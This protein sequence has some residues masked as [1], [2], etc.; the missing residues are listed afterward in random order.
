MHQVICPLRQKD[1]TSQMM[2]AMEDKWATQKSVKMMM[3]WWVRQ[4]KSIIYPGVIQ[5]VYWWI[6]FHS[7][8]IQYIQIYF[9]DQSTWFERCRDHVSFQK[10]SK[11]APFYSSVMLWPDQFQDK[12]RLFFQMSLVTPGYLLWPLCSVLALR[13]NN[14]P[15]S[16]SMHPKHAGLE[17]AIDPYISL[18][19]QK[20]T[21]RMN[22]AT[23]APTK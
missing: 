14:F 2:L 5:Y 23:G 12:Y 21:L 19:V 1:T 4:W 18:P 10:F 15:S 3:F 7:W 16:F 13:M 17:P 20:K 9:Q 11:S 22:F 6:R 8:F